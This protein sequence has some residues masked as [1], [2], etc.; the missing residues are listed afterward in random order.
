MDVVIPLGRSSCWRNNELRICLRSIEKFGTGFD[1]IFV[2]GEQPGFLSNRV[3]FHQVPEIRGNKEARI[4]FKIRWAFRK[5][6]IADD[7]VMFNDDFVLNAP[8]DLS[9]LGYYQRGPLGEAIVKQHNPT[10]RNSLFA[11]H[12]ALRAAGKPDL[13]YDIHVPMIYRRE[14]FLGL[15]AWWQRSLKD[16]H[17]FVVKSTYANNVLPEPGPYME[18]C[19]LKK[20]NAE[21]VE[22]KIAG[23][24]V[25]S[26]GDL[27]LQTGLKAWLQKRFPDK[28]SYE[29]GPTD[30]AGKAPAIQG[31]RPMRPN[32]K[33]RNGLRDLARFF[34]DGSVGIEV[35]AYAGESTRLFL[36]SGRVKKLICID[37]W[38]DNYYRGGQM[39]AAEKAFDALCL[40]Y[41][42]I[43]KIKATSERA[44]ARLKDEVDW[45]YID[46][47]H[48][49]NNVKQDIRLAL[50]LIKAPGG[51]V[52]GHDYHKKYPGVQGAVLKLLGFPDV[53]FADHSWL[54]F[55]DRIEV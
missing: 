28:S 25:Y 11:T 41:P 21:H 27:A 51:I 12:K 3:S 52:C 31:F 8:T 40:E 24:F 26:Y 29:R 55:V 36:E 32:P 42:Q 14:Q 20:F 7:A 5:T 49:E 30:I 18:D 53:V 38:M 35:G 15:E 10:Y 34:P 33:S 23:R 54:K 43:E 1:R 22:K 9:Q 39:A 2:I 6:D 46:G 37:A 44:L 48:H 17:G 47:N 4:A 45:A 50:K 16:R 13:H 19:K